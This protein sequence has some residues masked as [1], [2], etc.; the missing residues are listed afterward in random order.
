[1]ASSSSSS[2]QQPQ[3]GSGV[4]G[5]VVTVDLTGPDPQPFNGAGQYLFNKEPVNF[6]KPSATDLS[7]VGILHK[8][9]YSDNRTVFFVVYQVTDPTT[10]TVANPVSKEYVTCGW[11]DSQWVGNYLLEEWNAHKGY[12][13]WNQDAT[14]QEL[15]TRIQYEVDQHYR[16]LQGLNQQALLQQLTVKLVRLVKEYYGAIEDD[17]TLQAAVDEGFWGGIVKRDE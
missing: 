7:K 16:D 5:H 4:S 12:S 8:H 14:I 1:M 13:S 2:A 10:V 15:R 6:I 11:I 9:T 3:Q 17:R